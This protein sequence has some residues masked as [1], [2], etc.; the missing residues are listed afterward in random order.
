MRRDCRA[1]QVPIRPLPD[2][3]SSSDGGGVE[4]KR[5]AAA[6]RDG[7]RTSHESADGSN[8]LRSNN[9]SCIFSWCI[10]IYGSKDEFVLVVGW[11]RDLAVE[12]VCARRRTV[13]VL[14]RVA[15]REAKG[16]R[17]GR[18]LHEYNESDARFNEIVDRKMR[19]QGGITPLRDD[20]LSER[21]ES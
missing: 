13:T 19:Q 14:R 6:K 10:Q 11:V 12:I 15:S 5:L 7:R 18:N 8:M 9:V 16:T 21:D 20:R 1:R 4:S 2:G 17:V 3:T